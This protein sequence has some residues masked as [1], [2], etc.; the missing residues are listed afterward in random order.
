MPEPTI[1]A[2]VVCRAAA[3]LLWWRA[4][5]LRRRAGDRRAHASVRTGRLQEA[6]RLLE[7]ERA[8]MDLAGSTKGSLR[9]DVAG[10]VLALAQGYTEAM[11][12]LEDLLAAIGHPQASAVCELPAGRIDR[13][14][15]I[16]L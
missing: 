8:L 14:L 11:R 1:P 15:E 13:L 7:Q 6:E 2:S 10:L 3:A 4:D 16:L 5:Q 12:D 9:A